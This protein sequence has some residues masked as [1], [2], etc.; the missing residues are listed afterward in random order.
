MNNSFPKIAFTSQIIALRIFL[1]GDVGQAAK[2][3][4]SGSTRES[5]LYL[6]QRVE[7]FMPPRVLLNTIKITVASNQRRIIAL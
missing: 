5:R 3:G 6:G 2:T 4:R 7:E 1:G